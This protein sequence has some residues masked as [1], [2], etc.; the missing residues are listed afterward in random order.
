MT[1]IIIKIRYLIKVAIISFFV[2]FWQLPSYALNVQD[3]PNPRQ[4]YGGW[5]TDEALILSDEVENHLNKKISRLKSRNGAEIAIVTVDETS[6]EATPKLFAT[7]L[8]NYWGIGKDKE[9]N[10]I[11]LLV[12][13]NE[14]RIEI[15]TGLG[16]ES[17]IPNFKI[18]EIIEQDLTHLFQQDAF[19]LGIL[20]AIDDL[21]AEIDSGS[22]T[23]IFS[24]R[25]IVQGFALLWLLLILIATAVALTYG[26]KNR[27]KYLE[28][29]EVQRSSGSNH[30]DYGGISGSGS[31]F[32]GG[33]SDGGGAGGDW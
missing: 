28:Y 5:V 19:D 33:S 29:A 6:S 32:G 30:N 25:F 16:I 24:I 23:G 20:I 4:I 14:H 31:G 15:E 1:I 11:L 12:S 2:L 22:E 8:F 21:I 27:D 3:I 17:I 10:G 13:V 26:I 7:K 18:A 9:N